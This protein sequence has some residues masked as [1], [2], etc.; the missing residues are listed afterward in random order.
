M[1]LAEMIEHKLRMME[2]VINFPT[3]LIH[4]KAYHWENLPLA[5]YSNLTGSV[6]S[7]AGRGRKAAI[8]TGFY[9]PRGDPP[10]TET[11]GPPGAL[12]LAEGLKLMGLE[13]CLISDRYTVHALKVGL[14]ALGLSQDQ[15]P[16]IHFP[17]DHEEEN[18]VSRGTNEEA[19]DSA[20]T[21]F[22]DE[23]YRH[24]W[25]KGLTHLVYIERVGPNHTLGSFVAQ[26]R[27]GRPPRRD[28]DALVHP[29]MRNRCYN[30]RLQD[31]TRFT[32]KTHM[33]QE[34]VAQSDLP[35][36]TIGIGD[37]GNEIGAGCVPW[38]VYRDISENHHEALFACRICTDYFIS[39]GISNWG[40]YA[41]LAGVAL[42][43]GRLDILEKITSEQEMMLLDRLVHH[44]PAVDGIT[45]KQE[46]SVD[47]IHF[48]DYMKIIA[49]I[50][51][52]AFE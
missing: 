32:A 9:I 25:G 40:G 11:D 15:I 13:V 19:V 35:V 37:R 12:I 27:K 16:L 34:F 48:G 24:G 43:R 33:L 20:S 21:R 7:A 39:S 6:L 23:F 3:S 10:A 5:P 45:L 41:L 28:F 46:H 18:H 22:V 42:V 50:K 2:E 1:V 44:G 47:G 36:E 51:E 8:V 17:M 14:D 49:R 30:S 4:H 52:L 38:E 29:E 26:S 31:I